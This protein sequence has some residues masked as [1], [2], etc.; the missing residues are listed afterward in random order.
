M[1][2]FTTAVLALSV[3]LA[4]CKAKEALEQAKI[5]SELSKTGSTT[6]L[7]KQVADDTYDA[8]ADGKLTDAQVQM[9][10]KVREKEKAIA[11]VA[12]QQLKEHGDKAKA[13]GDKSIAGMVEGFKGLGS[14]ADF[15][16][17][18]LRAAKDLGFNTQEYTWVKGQIL[19][20]SSAEMGAKM[21]ETINAQMDASY[22]QMKKMYD[23]AKDEQTKAVYKQSLDAY[24]QQK[25]DAAAN[26]EPEDPALAH[27]RQLLAKYE[28]TLNAFASEMSKYADNP[29]DAKKSVQEWEKNLDKAKADAQ[30]AQQ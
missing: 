20:V 14:V 1:R 23:E 19:A 27:N 3:A 5:A 11:Q 8:P 24:E 15:L 25:K 21:T 2:R 28:N 10:L 22:Q 16:T 26:K 29:T 6:K 18:D 7:M 13:A 30:K 12:K 17:A 9:Y 4:G